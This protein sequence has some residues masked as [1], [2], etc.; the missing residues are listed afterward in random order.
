MTGQIPVPNRTCQPRLTLR[1]KRLTNFPPTP[2]YQAL[3][4]DVWGVPIMHTGTQVCPGLLCGSDP[5]HASSGERKSLV[6][7]PLNRTLMVFW[8]AP[9]SSGLHSRGLDVTT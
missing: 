7:V 9:L 8:A 4:R 1:P 6:T 3:V 5:L 2:C